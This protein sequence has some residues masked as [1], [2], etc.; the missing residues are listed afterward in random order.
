M[1]EDFNAKS[2]PWLCHS[3]HCDFTHMFFVWKSPMLTRNQSDQLP[4]LGRTHHQ[5]QTPVKQPASVIPTPSI[6]K[7]IFGENDDEHRVVLQKT[8]LSQCTVKA[9]ALFRLRIPWLT[10]SKERHV[11]PCNY[12]LWQVSNSRVVLL[13]VYKGFKPN[14]FDIEPVWCLGWQ[15]SEY[16]GCTTHCSL[17]DIRSIPNWIKIGFSSKK[18]RE[19]VTQQSIWPACPLP[20]QPLSALEP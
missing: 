4:A 7:F 19:T 2:W 17:P 12:G 6:S 11:S 16:L 14:G 9:R 20:Q 15:S 18:R 13:N 3:N 5:L 1:I 10:L 8:F